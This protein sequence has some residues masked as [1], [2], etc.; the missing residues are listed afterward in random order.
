L[1]RELLQGSSSS[2]TTLSVSSLR[3][4][5]RD[6]N[7]ISGGVEG[8]MRTIRRHSAGFV[9][10]FVL[11]ATG[12]GD[13]QSTTQ[14]LAA[15]VSPY[16]KLSVPATV[17]LQ[18]GGTGFATG[19]T[20]SLTVS[21]WARTSATG[22]GSMTVQ[23]NSNFSPAGGPSIG[24]VTY[25]CSGATL[26]SGCT[27]TQILGLA[28]QTGLISLPGGVCTGGSGTCSAQDPNTVLLSFS[29]LNKPQHKTGTYSA[30]ITFTISTM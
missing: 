17:N 27:G 26:G 28:T 4:L 23:A 5:M 6:F 10:A 15:N 29:A 18:S 3:N 12:I 22:G 25:I 2:I 7:S 8:E 24:G 1:P 11:P 19:L 14:T 30:Q 21:Y 9:L 16:G 20:G 13:I